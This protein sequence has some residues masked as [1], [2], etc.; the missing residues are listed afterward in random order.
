MFGDR[1]TA[2][3]AMI[4][5]NGGGLDFNPGARPTAE[6]AQLARQAAEGRA[7]LLLRGM[8]GRPTAD[9][10]VIAVHGDGYVVFA[11]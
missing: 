9:L 1:T 7:L 2:D 10:C 8:G 3:L 4:L 6:L 11:D 5:S